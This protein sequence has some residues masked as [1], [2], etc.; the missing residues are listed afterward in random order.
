MTATDNIICD[1]CG[2]PITRGAPYPRCGSTSGRANLQASS[3]ASARGGATPS[4]RANLRASSVAS[5]GGRATV[6]GSALLLTASLHWVALVHRIWFS[7]VLSLVVAVASYF[8]GRR[9]EHE[10]LRHRQ[11]AN[12]DRVHLEHQDM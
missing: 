7:V 12:R 2:E 8:V 4:G 6:T 1:N 10:V 3:V 11:N 9:M 5:A